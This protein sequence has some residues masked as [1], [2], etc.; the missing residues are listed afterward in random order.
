MQWTP[1][2]VAALVSCATGEQ[3]EQQRGSIITGYGG[4]DLD[5]SSG[6]TEDGGSPGSETG[7]A[8]GLPAGSGGASRSMGSGG[9]PSS[10]TG[11]RFAAGAAGQSAA[12]SG[13]V[14]GTAVGGRAG[15]VGSSG[16]SGT[17]ARGGAAGGNVGNGGATSG[18]GGS[19]NCSAAEKVCSGVCTQ[20]SPANGCSAPNCSACAAAPANG[21][22][23]CNAQG[24]CD[25]DCLSGFQKSGN[26]CTRG[27]GTGGAGGG[28]AGGSGGSVV[29]GGETCQSCPGDQVACCDLLLGR[30]ICAIKNLA[31]ALCR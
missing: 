23:S 9:G 16:A 14:A 17:G 30:C 18:A 5:A 22:R 26:Q 11:G 28:G 24:Q 4:S 10:S 13:G 21:V 8:P 20:K 31:P 6:S 15:S 27:T 25:F 2:L 3:L 12:S 19:P 29:C 1:V 7:G